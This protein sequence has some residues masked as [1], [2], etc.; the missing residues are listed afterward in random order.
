VNAP[1][2]IL[3]IRL[4]A[5]GDVIFTLPASGVLRRQFPAAKITFLTSKENASLLR[6]FPEV[7]ETI[8]LDRAA[9]RSGNPLKIIR[10]FFGL[11]YR[12]RAGRFSLVVDFQ[13]F[14]ET[15]WLSR[16]TGAPQRWGTV[17]GSGRSWAYTQGAIRDNNVHPA[18]WNLQLLA[19]AGV[20]S[21]LVQNQFRLPADSLAAAQKFFAE[22]HLDPTQPTLLIQPFTSTPQKNWPLENFLAVARHWRA[23]GVQVIFAGGPADRLPLALA[24]AEKFCVAAGLPLL[25]SAGLARFATLTL[26]GDSGL[27][28]LGVAQ[29]RR[30]VML[31]MHAR[32]GACVPFQHPEWAITPEKPGRIR[33]ISVPTVLAETTRVFNLPGGNASC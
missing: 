14:G 26:G 27:G 7:N 21:G 9:L 13:G 23:R 5:I 3:L 24:A 29:Q 8:A 22:N 30:V 11:L 10:E 1:N 17:Y 6:G 16:F 32:P 4:K 15:A 33:D 19:A 20:K 28:H 18:E 12:L 25:V 2:N 31:M